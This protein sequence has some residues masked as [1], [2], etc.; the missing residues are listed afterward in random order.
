MSESVSAEPMFPD[1]SPTGKLMQLVL[2]A[3]G[4][5]RGRHR[6]RWETVSQVRQSLRCLLSL[7][8]TWLAIRSQW[9][10]A[11]SLL[12]SKASEAVQGT[13]GSIHY[14][15]MRLRSQNENTRKAKETVTSCVQAEWFLTF[16]ATVRKAEQL[17]QT[18]DSFYDQT[19]RYFYDQL[20]KWKDLKKIC[21]LHGRM[22]YSVLLA[23]RMGKLSPQLNGQHKLFGWHHTEV[24]HV[25]Q[26]LQYTK[27]ELIAKRERKGPAPSVVVGRHELQIRHIYLKPPG[28][29]KF[30]R[31][32]RVKDWCERYQPPTLGSFQTQVSL[33][34]A[35]FRLQKAGG[36]AATAPQRGAT[37][38][39]KMGVDTTRI[40]P[41]TLI[42]GE[43]E[44]I[45]LNGVKTNDY[46]FPAMWIEQRGTSLTRRTNHLV[47]S[48]VY[49]R[50]GWNDIYHAD[51]APRYGIENTGEPEKPTPEAVVDQLTLS[52]QSYFERLEW[53]RQYAKDRLLRDKERK[54]DL[55][56]LL[57][58]LR[59]VPLVALADSYAVGNCRPGTADFCRLLKIETETIN[60]QDLAQR[61]YKSGY[62]SQDRFLNVMERA[63]KQ[64]EATL[65]LW[66]IT[67]LPNTASTEPIPDDV[68][69]THETPDVPEDLPVSLPVPDSLPEGEPS[70]GH[71]ESLVESQPHSRYDQQEEA[72]QE[73]STEEGGREENHQQEAAA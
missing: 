29:D 7:Q 10:E 11:I 28:M 70:D 56:R 60:G 68:Y 4:I 40:T 65:E 39:R 27:Q 16:A 58:K 12:D 59:N 71:E 32:N 69:S 6:L 34:L 62:V 25:L 5:L 54:R 66:Q 30:S 42:T 52:S 3:E 8:A 43:G 38:L 35:Y 55:G 14:K 48:W 13:G 17:A 53:E 49:A 33:C 36:K 20:P 19:E 61:W 72:S 51:P 50:A 23:C 67:A 9:M 18:L 1:F 2:K 37:F 15:L 46:C 47:Q 63:V 31:I 57:R 26:A 44:R 24:T 64:H 41:D 45:I 73:G 21:P 22:A